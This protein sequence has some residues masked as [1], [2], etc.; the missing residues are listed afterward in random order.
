MHVQNAKK[1]YV[2][3]NKHPYLPKARFTYITLAQMFQKQCAPNFI[4]HEFAAL[5]TSQHKGDHALG[6]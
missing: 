1:I 4:L 5:Q 3:Q 6:G 2:T